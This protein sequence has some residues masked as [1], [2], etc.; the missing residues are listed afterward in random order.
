MNLFYCPD[1]LET[2]AVLSA[3][4]SAHCIR[5]L[6][7]RLGDSLNLIDGKGHL[8]E[9]IIEEP[10]PSKCRVT[11]TR[12]EIMPP[13][14]KSKLHIAIAPTKSIDRFEWFVEK[15]IEIGIDEITPVICQRSERRSIKTDRLDRLVISTMKQAKVFHKPEI[16][17][18][19]SFP[20]FIALQVNYASKIIAHCNESE[21]YDIKRIL[22][23][24]KNITVLIGPEGDFTPDEIKCAT[25]AGFIPAD[26]GQN[27]LRTETAG[28]L[29]CS[30]FNFIN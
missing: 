29:V 5:V 6:R 7:M 24:E 14:R 25:D 22:Y 23:P 15:A 30:A 4:E 27:R 9:G 1:I 3:E 10:D 21:K 11:I 8:Y 2:R 18:P 17:M 12:K 26:L 19:I 16:H 13:Q 20:G 28:I